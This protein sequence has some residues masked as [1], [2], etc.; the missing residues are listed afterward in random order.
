[1]ATSVEKVQNEMSVLSDIE[2]Q[3]ISG[4]AVK[5]EIKF[6]FKLDATGKPAAT[7]SYSISW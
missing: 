2:L 4:G 6:E 5:Q 3:E 1:M 7:V